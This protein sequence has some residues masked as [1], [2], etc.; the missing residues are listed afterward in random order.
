LSGSTHLFF[1]NNKTFMMT[2]SS[3]PTMG[4][5]GSI[6]GTNQAPGVVTKI[7]VERVSNGYLIFDAVTPYNS[8]EKK[9]VKTLKEATEVMEDIFVTFLD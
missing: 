5:L 4:T 8:L 6:A 9:Y 7:N 3:Q 2:Q 1:K